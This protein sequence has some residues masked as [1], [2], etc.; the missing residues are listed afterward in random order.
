MVSLNQSDEAEIR[1]LFDRWVRDLSTRNLDAPKSAVPT[2]TPPLDLD[3]W[4]ASWPDS[5]GREMR[6]LMIGADGVAFCHSRNRTRSGMWVR[7][8]VALRKIEGQWRV[9]HERIFGVPEGNHSA[10]FNT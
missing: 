4:F 9:M 8:T 10:A 5:A 2:D 6:C 1:Q 7:A 3:R